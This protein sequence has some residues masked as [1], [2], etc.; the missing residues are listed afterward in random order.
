MITNKDLDW[1]ETYYPGMIYIP[2]KNILRGCLWFRAVY[3][4]SED[5]CIINPQVGEDFKGSIFLEDAYELDIEFNDLQSSAKARETAGRLKW[6]AKKWGVNLID[7][8]VYSDNT[9]CLHPSP[10]EDI[11]F[12]NGITIESFF[13][14]LLIPDLFY[15]SFFEKT[16]REPW[17]GSSHGDLGIFESYKREFS[18][19]MPSKNILEAYLRALSE[20]SCKAIVYRHPVKII[21]LCL[22][23][24]GRRFSDC[25]KDA[26][27]GYQKIYSHF[28][29]ADYGLTVSDIQPS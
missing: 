14:K 26:F 13:T 11:K 8:H 18:A 23:R 22:C 27:D 20:S 15:Q 5:I 6:S 3:R 17:R 25:H 10:E 1:L 2:R 24:S 9:L 28:C 4:S 12:S 19:K 16:G 29:S 7:I 21:D